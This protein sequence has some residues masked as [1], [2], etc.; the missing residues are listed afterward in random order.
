MDSR[1]IIQNRLILQILLENKT[2][3]KEQ[4]DNLFKLEHEEQNKQINE[5]L[6]GDKQ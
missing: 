1:L 4:Y 6:W 5:I 2:I 3:T